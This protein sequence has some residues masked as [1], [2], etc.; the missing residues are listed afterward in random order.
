MLHTADGPIAFLTFA[1]SDQTL[2][3]VSQ[4]RDIVRTWRF[5]PGARP[6]LKVSAKGIKRVLASPHH[7]LVLLLCH[8][9]S[10]AVILDTRSGLYLTTQK[11]LVAAAFMPDGRSF[12]SWSWD[13]GANGM[14]MDLWD[15]S[16]LLEHGISKDS[17]T[18]DRL[19]PVKIV[20]TSM[21]G[22]QVRPY[23]LA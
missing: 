7:A 1:D 18:K 13:A 9:G 6:P 10:R 19:E 14:G 16:P 21:H 17:A 22:P 2:V 15:L 23:V 12:I 4:D 5:G 11:A 8:G 3:A 20:S